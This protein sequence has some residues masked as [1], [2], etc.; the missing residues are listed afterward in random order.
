MY[1]KGIKFINDFV[2]NDGQMMK[3]DEVVR[4]YPFLR[5]NLLCVQGL[6]SAIP[7]SWKSAIRRSNVKELGE[8]ERVGI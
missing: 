3:V 1:R 7:D 6:L 5:A 2:N 8:D 4:R